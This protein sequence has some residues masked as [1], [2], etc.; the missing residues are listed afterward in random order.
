MYTFFNRK[1]KRGLA[2]LLRFALCCGPSGPGGQAPNAAERGQPALGGGG[3]RTTASTLTGTNG[4]NHTHTNGPAANGGRALKEPGPDNGAQLRLQQQRRRRQLADGFAG[5]QHTG[6]C[7]P[8]VA[9]AAKPA[10]LLA[11]ERRADARFLLANGEANLGPSSG[12]HRATCSLGAC[13]RLDE[14]SRRRWRRQQQQ[15]QQHHLR[16]LAGE[17]RLCASRMG[18]KSATAS[19]AGPQFELGPR[20]A[21]GELRA[22]CGRARARRP[23]D[24]SC[25]WRGRCAH[26]NCRRSGHLC[27]CRA[28][29]PD[30][31]EAAAAAAATTKAARSSDE[32]DDE[33]TPSTASQVRRSSDGPT[34]AGARKPAEG[35]ANCRASIDDAQAALAQRRLQQAGGS[36]CTDNSAEATAGSGSAQTTRSAQVGGRQQQQRTLPCKG[37]RF[38]RKSEGDQV[39]PDQGAAWAS[40]AKRGNGRREEEAEEAAKRAASD[41]IKRLGRPQQQRP[42][43][44]CRPRSALCYCNQLCADHHEQ[45]DKHLASQRRL[46]GEL[47]GAGQRRRSGSSRAPVECS[48]DSKRRGSLE[49]GGQLK[50]EANKSVEEAAAAAAAK[51]VEED[52]LLFGS[53]GETEAESA[54]E[55]NPLAATCGSLDQMRPGSGGGGGHSTVACAGDHS[56][57]CERGQRNHHHRRYHDNDYNH[58]N[59]HRHRRHHHH[60]HHHHHNHHHHPHLHPRHHHHH[61]HLHE[62]DNQQPSGSGNHSGHRQSKLVPPKQERQL[63]PPAG[64]T[65]CECQ[66]EWPAPVQVAPAEQ[67]DELLASWQRRR[68]RAR[69]SREP[70]ESGEPAQNGAPLGEEV[71]REREE[72]E[73]EGGEL[74]RPKEDQDERPK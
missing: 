12:A 56:S 43:S 24:S 21:L 71:A 28:P 51:N 16:Q 68:R 38:N 53:D 61:H 54:L 70:S 55:M 39:E 74:G 73:E 19:G 30:A 29:A 26:T 48:H 20:G 5:R 35:G 66:L 41:E 9:C 49:A 59:H 62:H 23:P 40:A 11:F 8:P 46:S 6:G 69:R 42:A 7:A 13:C 65:K 33:S 37:P 60:H 22:A 63:R 15:Q 44:H 47:A 50:L 52:R 27:A 32:M 10:E 14:Q 31:R 3:Q 72:K 17:C 34:R 45:R 18:A 2:D 36:S 64:E 57:G 58:Q 1:Y 4:A 67:T 25:R